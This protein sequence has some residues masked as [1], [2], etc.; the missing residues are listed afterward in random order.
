[1][2][3]TYAQISNSIVINIVIADDSDYFNSAY[4]WIN[5]AGLNPMP[6]I[7]WTYSGSFSPP[8]PTLPTLAVAIATNIAGFQS[9]INE[10]VNQCYSIETRL[11]F[12]GLYINAQING[13]TNRMA[14]IA[15]LLAWQNSVIQYAAGYVASISAETDVPTVLATVPNFSALTLSNPNLSPIAALRIPN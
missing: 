4:M 8:V 2:I 3:N 9:S 6:L 7:G 15:P 12:M 13:L 11:N 5:L 10:F 14:Y 1:M